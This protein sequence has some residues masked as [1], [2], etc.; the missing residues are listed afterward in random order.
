MGSDRYAARNMA[1]RVGLRGRA[2]WLIALVASLF[3]LGAWLSWPSGQA[4]ACGSF[5]KKT[6]LGRKPSLAYEQ[7]LIVYDAATSTQHFIREVAFKDAATSFGFVVPTPS[8][9]E[10]GKVTR[11]PFDL[12]R[13]KFPFAPAAGIGTIGHG[14]GSGTGQGFGSG[15]GSVTVLDELKIG[16]F[17]AFVLAAD[18]EG[19]LSKWLNDN[20][21]GTTPESQEW[22][23]HY[24]RMKFFYVALRYDPPKEADA[25]KS[26]KPP[27]TRSETLRVSFATPAPY[28]PY[29]EPK[30]PAGLT[31]SN[32]LLELWLIS[33]EPQS[34]VALLENEQGRAWV[35]PLQPGVTHTN[36][37]EAATAAL[38][39]ELAK[40]LPG[41]P[42][43]VQTFQDQKF[44]RQGFGDILFVPREKRE[45]EPAR[46][47]AL[48]QLVGVLDSS[49]VPP[50]AEP[51]Q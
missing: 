51:A 36:G 5:F 8:K 42:L 24:V 31:S 16:S 25:S 27:P 17:T 41:G 11:P 22:L 18:D 37:R 40:L 48:S 7:V 33:S 35:R 43:T 15:R 29:L 9:P 2:W 28:Y 47:A 45:L 12:L 10:V 13:T 1:V 39:S 19:A 46:K 32:R 3:G 38:G 30:P 44:S 14:G 4:A 49:L 23:G 34:P 20:G 26:L 6:E 50:R 21:L